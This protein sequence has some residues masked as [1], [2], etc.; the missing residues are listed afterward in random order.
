[1]NTDTNII[2]SLN[3][4]WALHWENTNTFYR[5]CD[6]IILRKWNHFQT[7]TSLIKL[8]LGGA[9]LWISISIFWLSPCSNHLRPSFYY[10]SFNSGDFLKKFSKIVWIWKIYIYGSWFSLFCL[11]SSSKPIWNCDKNN[12]CRRICHSH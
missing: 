7:K 6:G 8:P 5:T 1:M 9:A 3:K 2:G 11:T 4:L 12:V 10:A